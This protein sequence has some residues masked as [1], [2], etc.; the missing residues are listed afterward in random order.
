MSTIR[1]VWAA[2]S[3]NKKIRSISSS[4]GVFY[5][6]SNH[7]LKQGGVV[8]GVSMSEDNR[9]AEYIRACDYNSLI[10]ILGSKYIQAK[11]GDTYKRVK[12]DLDNRV[13]VLFSGTGCIINGLK[14]FLNQDYDN[15]FC[16]EVVCHGVPS[17]KLWERYIIDIEEREKAKVK[18][19]SFRSKDYG[20]ESF[21][22]SRMSN[23]EKYIFSPAGSDVFMQMFL[24]NYCL[25]PSCYECLAKK[26]RYA[27]IS[28]GD[29]WG[30][31]SIHPDMND[32]MGTSLVIIRS[33]KGSKL[34]EAIHGSLITKEAS[35]DE[36][37]KNNP[38]EYSSVDRPT[39]RDSFFTDLGTMPFKKLTKKYVPLSKKQII[40]KA[41]L[42]TPL[43]KVL[44]GGNMNWQNYSLL[45]VLKNER[46]HREGKVRK[47]CLQ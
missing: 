35:Y 26:Q 7:I 27:D 32:G 23:A 34:F 12:N 47:P 46:N 40:K 22:L 25:R 45:F 37:V 3:D 24:K 14:A 43:G 31:D 9:G 5:E 2:L 1:R 42:K 39:E 17:P 20:W 36:A 11:V 13:N 28:L 44:G 30:I 8:Y 33:E 15:L 29:F 16:I 19:V 21:G 38:A 6:L 10:R 41:L 4:G 18:S